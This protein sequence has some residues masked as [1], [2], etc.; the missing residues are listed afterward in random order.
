MKH[1]IERLMILKLVQEYANKHGIEYTRDIRPRFAAVA[2]HIMEHSK[3]DQESICK[4]C[5]E[6]C[7]GDLCKLS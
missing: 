6:E 5:V 3:A 4:G 1:A 7:E 2:K